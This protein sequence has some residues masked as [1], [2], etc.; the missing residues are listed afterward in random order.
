VPEQPQPGPQVPFIDEHLLFV[1]KPA[2]LLAVPGRGEA[3]RICLSAQVQQLVPDALIVHR[4]D[5][6][7]SGLMV[8]AR[9]LPALRRLSLAFEQR[10]VSKRYVAVVDGWLDDDEGQIDAPLIADWLARPRQI[11]D[12]EIGKPSLTF[13]RVLAREPDRRTRLELTPVTGRSHQLRVH[14]ASIGHPILGD[15]LYAAPVITEAAPR[16]LLHASALTVPHPVDGRAMSFTSPTP[17]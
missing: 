13:W 6:G 16:M 10:R 5:M 4:L 1:D 15:G 7:T 14:L 2:G 11:I 3:G 8:F 17:F 12:R 9:G